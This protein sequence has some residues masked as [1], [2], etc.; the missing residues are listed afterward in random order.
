[1]VNG[2]P[3]LSYIWSCTDELKQ[4]LYKDV[5]IVVK[6]TVP[7]G[8]SFKIYEHLQEGNKLFHSGSLNIEIAFC[9]EFLKQGNAVADTMRPD[10]IIIGCESENARKVLQRLYDSFT[11]N[12]SR[13]LLMPVKDAEM[14]KYVANAML[15]TRISFM[16]EMSLICDSI[17]VDIEYVRKGIGSILE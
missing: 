15:A 4:S 5:I 9:P 14:T 16:N 10:R 12:H 2:D 1:M 3:D 13:T 17:G 8:T 6:S 11:L 7:V